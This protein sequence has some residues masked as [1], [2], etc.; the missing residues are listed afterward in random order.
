MPTIDLENSIPLDLENPAENRPPIAAEDLAK[1]LSALQGNI[2]KSH[3]RDFVEIR[4]LQLPA[5]STP[6]GATQLRALLRALE[7]FV[8]SA[9]EQEQQKKRHLAGGEQEAFV[10]VWLT[11]HSLRRLGHGPFQD[12]RKNWPPDSL[13]WGG[14]PPLNQ[15]SI[16]L[17]QGEREPIGLAVLIAHDRR[18][19][20][21]EHW[22]AMQA[23]LPAAG[24][25]LRP[26]VE[27]GAQLWAM[28]T[29]G[30]VGEP[31]EVRVEHFG[32]VDGLSQPQ[33][34]KTDEGGGPWNAFQPLGRVLFSEAALAGPHAFG[35]YFTLQK[36]EQ[37]PRAFRAAAEASGDAE[38]HYAQVMGRDRHGTPLVATP[39]GKLNH[40][41]YSDG[42]P[43]EPG[44]CPFHVH[45]RRANPRDG[46]EERKHLQRVL[47]P[48]RSI[49]YGARALDARGNLDETGEL[50]SGGVGLLFMGCM[51]DILRQFSEMNGRWLVAGNFPEDNA[52]SADPVVRGRGLADEPFVKPLG[53]LH[54]YAPSK[55]ALVKL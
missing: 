17:D 32:Y 45:I 39:P 37:N 6:E 15:V 52:G 38:R 1:F 26:E 9:A 21:E 16:A 44:A 22:A 40:F 14:R 36:L 27:L 11:H 46:R 54:F 35:S 28:R 4:Y 18:D 42:A 25:T 5:E 10:S 33:L 31:R 30:C 48:R 53:G 34:L 41:N 50:P 19:G 24:W 47:F 51:S 13:F 8:T 12:I 2:L 20:A 43:G 29:P 3:G 7:P 23:Q 49:P 55:T